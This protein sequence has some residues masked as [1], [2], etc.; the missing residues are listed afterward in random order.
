MQLRDASIL[1][2]DDEPMLR[3]IF[4]DWFTNVAGR[5]LVAENEAHA[6]E[7]WPSTTL[8]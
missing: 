5:V 1:V 7:V 6:L 8:T 3:E 2:V 4:A